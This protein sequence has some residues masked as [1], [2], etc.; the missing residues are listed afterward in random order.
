MHLLSPGY[1]AEE[2]FPLTCS[3]VA[4]HSYGRHPATK[5]NRVTSR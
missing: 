2:G 4:R 1:P 5:D 3:A